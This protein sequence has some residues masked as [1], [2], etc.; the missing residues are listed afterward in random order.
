M[1]LPA[2]AATVRAAFHVL[3]DTAPGG[4][5]CWRMRSLLALSTT[6]LLV[7]IERQAAALFP[8]LLD[9]TAAFEP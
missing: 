3:F 7:R 9:G 5:P 6:L 4:R 1:R 8:M 2:D